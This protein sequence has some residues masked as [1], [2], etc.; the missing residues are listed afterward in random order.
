MKRTYAYLFLRMRVAQL[1][2]VGVEMKSDLPSIFKNRLD[3]TL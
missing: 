3:V 1:I 2:F